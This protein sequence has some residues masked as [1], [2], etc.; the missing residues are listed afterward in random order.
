MSEY[1]GGPGA[2]HPQIPN[3]L[4]F[5]KVYGAQHAGWDTRSQVPLGSSSLSG[6]GSAMVA[7]SSHQSPFAGN[8]TRSQFS[9]GGSVPSYPSNSGYSRFAGQ[10]T[11]SSITL[12]NFGGD[13]S[14]G[15]QGRVQQAQPQRASA[16]YATGPQSPVVLHTHMHQHQ[17]QMQPGATSP[18][19]SA[20]P[21]AEAFAGARLSPARLSPTH[22]QKPWASAPPAVNADFGPVSAEQ[23]NNMIREIAQLRVRNAE[24]E[25]LEQYT[26]QLEARLRSAG[27]L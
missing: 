26:Q 16:P 21:P 15:F 7:S 19:A 23:V 13:G 2:P 27:L 3:G 24:L 20:P 1:G 12:A 5:D 4:G 10:S 11:R 6:A 8:A 25:S 18:Y 17:H 14:V 22:D 9:F